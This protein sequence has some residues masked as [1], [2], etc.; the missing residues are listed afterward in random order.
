M[1]SLYF[2]YIKDSINMTTSNSFIVV[3]NIPNVLSPLEA[4]NGLRSILNRQQERFGTPSLIRIFQSQNDLFQTAFV[5]YSNCDLNESI[6]RFFDNTNAFGS[7]LNFILENRRYAHPV[8]INRS[9]GLDESSSTRLNLLPIDGNEATLS[10]TANS[11][12]GAGPNVVQSIINLDTTE[13]VSTQSS[14]SFLT[15]PLNAS[16]PLERISSVN[17]SLFK[18]NRC[19]HN[20]GNNQ[21]NFEDHVEQC[22]EKE[23]E[24]FSSSIRNNICRLCYGRYLQTPV[25]S[26]H[27]L[28]CGHLFH[29]ECFLRIKDK[30]FCPYCNEIVYDNWK[31]AFYL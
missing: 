9:L 8:E 3:K 13:S 22:K 1:T 27:I 23:D 11:G 17:N 31:G 2:K 24:S 16:T 19:E 5:F 7:N 15:V 30:N 4:E 18:C 10:A 14:D 12:G 28:P 25:N 26:M 20:F 6:V 29:K 21:E